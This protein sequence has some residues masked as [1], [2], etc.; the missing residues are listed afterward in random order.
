MS[1]TL[2]RSPLQLLIRFSSFLTFLFYCFY[3]YKIFFFFSFPST[4]TSSFPIITSSFVL[5]YFF[6]LSSS[7]SSPIIA[8]PFFSLPLFLPHYFTILSPLL[9]FYKSKRGEEGRLKNGDQARVKGIKLLIFVYLYTPGIPYTQAHIHTGPHNCNSHV[10]CDPYLQ[11]KHMTLLRHT[12]IHTRA[13]TC[14]TCP[15]Y[16]PHLP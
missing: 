6:F 3:F 4:A 1:L 10:P 16:H 14:S 8:K 5:S 2:Y 7:L 13:H 9:A 12:L 15:L 11:Y